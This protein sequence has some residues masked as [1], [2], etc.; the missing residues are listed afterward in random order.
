MHLLILLLLLILILLL[1]IYPLRSGPQRYTRPLGNVIFCGMERYLTSINPQLCYEMLEITDRI[2]KKH[3]VEFWLAE[4]TA[5]GAVRDGC[6]LPYDSDVDICMWPQFWPAFH[7]KVVP[8]LVQDYGFMIYK[9]HFD[10]DFITLRY[11]GQYLD[12]NSIVPGSY[13]TS[14]PGPCDE[15]IPH[16]GE[17]QDVVLPCSSQNTYKSPGKDYLLFLYGPT[18]TIPRPGV[19]PIDVINPLKLWGFFKA[20]TIEGTEVVFDTGSFTM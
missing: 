17:L 8:E 2:C 9:D 12:I 3:G 16:I 15:L 5:L 4:G 14:V 11:R 1:C 6:V 19:K 7:D 18:W 10:Y 20:P 13:C